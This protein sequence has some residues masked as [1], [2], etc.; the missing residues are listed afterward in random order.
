MDYRFRAGQQVQLRTISSN[1]SVVRAWVRVLY[2]DGNDDTLFI[3]DT[4]LSASRAIELA[5]SEP[6]E[7]AGWVVAAAVEMVSTGVKRGQTYTLLS[8]SPFGCELAHDYCY[9]LVPVALG[10]FRESGP[11]GGSGHLELQEVKAVGAPAA[12]TTVFLPQSNMLRQLKYF[13]WIY[14]CSADVATRTLDVRLRYFLGAVPGGMEVFTLAIWRPASLVLT[15]SEDGMMFADEKRSG[16]ND[17]QT[18]TIDDGAANPT[19]FPLMISEDQVSTFGFDFQVTN[20]NANDLD[21]IYLLLEEW[22]TL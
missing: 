6:A 17:N 15:A 7:Q 10:T 13:S 22:L 16:R 5:F 19:P 21:A 14:S 1:A 18:L 9:S 8:F 2:D 4:P 12:G 11:G 3:A 20:G